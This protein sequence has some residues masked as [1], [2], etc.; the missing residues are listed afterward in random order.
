MSTYH[1]VL[2]KLPANEA[3]AQTAK[4]LYEVC[5]GLQDVSEASTAL[6]QL[7]KQGKISRKAMP[8]GSGSAFCYWN[9]PYE[10]EKAAEPVANK[11]A[12]PVQQ[13][14]QTKPAEPVQLV[15]ETGKNKT[16]QDPKDI[17]KASLAMLADAIAEKVEAEKAAQSKSVEI[18]Q[19]QRQ[20]FELPSNWRDIS[21]MPPQ[22]PEPKPSPST[23]INEIQNAVPK[24]SHILISAGGSLFVTPHLEDIIK[25]AQVLK[26][27]A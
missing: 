21:A 5:K 14:Q 10:L 25:I 13:A 6:S 17:A 16:S 23:S 20:P 4:Q 24:G 26:G 11:P 9:Q 3:D 8:P 18:P 2:S 27:S 7:F 22:P 12:T 19:K 15:N 1:E